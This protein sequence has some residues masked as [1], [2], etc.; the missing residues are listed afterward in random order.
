MRMNWWMAPLAVLLVLVGVAGGLYLARP[1]A[2]VPAGPGGKVQAPSASG[3][4][5]AKPPAEQPKPAEEPPKPVEEPK[6]A[7]PAPK[8]PSD[9][10]AQAFVRTFMEARM[11]GNAGK[12]SA[13]VASNATTNG[14]IRLSGPG[15]RIAGYTA[16]LLGSGDTDSFSFSLKVAFA[17]GQPGSEVEAEE[18]RLTWKGG[19]KV[20]AY[21]DAPKES[22][23]LG[24]GQDGKLWLHRGQAT[25]MVGDLAGLP[26]TFKPMGAAPGTEFGVG[27]DGWSVAAVNTAGTHVLWVTKGLHPLLGISQVN[28]Q[29]NPTVTP[30]DLLFEA[31]GVDAAWAPGSARY[32]AVAVAQ[33]S[34]A[35]ALVIYD[36]TVPAK[37]GPDLVT[38][39]G[40]LDFTVRNL[41]WLSATVV[42][43][44][45]QKGSATTG[46][47]TYDINSKKLTQP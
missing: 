5:S 18:L 15:A 43:F 4:S 12:V 38:T 9:A 14:P 8:R 27:K 40:N 26:N 23:A 2:A 3:G 31:G 30:L 24:V 28:W 22:L 19:L 6:P 10:E 25:A 13:M 33:P 39:F 45:V 37:F 11:A 42:A 47:Y 17:T 7:E 16:Q 29:G 36:A 20:A 46:P 32:V 35:T 1:K 44:D 21:T 34:G 41:R